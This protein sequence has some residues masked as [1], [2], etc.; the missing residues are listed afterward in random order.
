L[1]KE[2]DKAQPRTK[3]QFPLM[4]FL[5]LVHLRRDG[6]WMPAN[7]VTRTFAQVQWTLRGV[8]CRELCKDGVP[9][10]DDSG[11]CLSDSWP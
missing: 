8:C 6:S 2:E 11:R 9:D 3:Y 4:R 7:L 10:Q 1:L 5:C